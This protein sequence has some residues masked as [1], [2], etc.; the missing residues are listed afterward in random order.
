MKKIISVLTLM[1]ICASLATP[2]VSAEEKEIIANGFW[3]IGENGQGTGVETEI[4]R[5]KF[6][7][8]ID[9]DGL[10]TFNA[11]DSNDNDEIGNQQN[12]ARN[13]WANWKG[14]IKKVVIP[15]G[16]KIVGGRLFE[17]YDSVE[18]AV[19]PDSCET[20]MG[21][22]VGCRNMT[23]INIPKRI[24]DIKLTYSGVNGEIVLPDT[25][26]TIKSE[27]FQGTGIS[28]ITIN[29]SDV[30][31]DAFL[32]AQGLNE[33]YVYGDS[34]ISAY[35]F[36]NTVALNK[37]VL[38]PDVKI[39][40]NAVSSYKEKTD[41]KYPDTAT[42]PDNMKNGTVFGVTGTE[43][44]RYAKNNNIKFS[45]FD[46]IGNAGDVAWNVVD[47]KLTISGSGA[48]P[49]YTIEDAPW[50]GLAD[51]IRTIAISDGVTAIGNN[52]FDGLNNVK[53]AII[54]NGVTRIGTK[55]FAGCTRLAAVVI[56]DSVNEIADDAFEPETAACVGTASVYANKNGFKTYT[57]GK[58]SDSDISDNGQSNINWAVYGNDTLVISGTGRM[59]NTWK[60]AVPWSGYITKLKT[61]VVDYGITWQTQRLFKGDGEKYSSLETVIMADGI[62]RIRKDEI[63]GCTVLKRYDPSNKLVYLEDYVFNGNN[64]IKELVLPGTLKERQKAL[65][66]NSVGFENLIMEE[67]FN[68]LTEDVDN[69][70][71]G[72][73]VRDAGNLKTLKFPKSVTRI[74]TYSF[75]L[76]SNLERIEFLNPDTV[77]ADGAFNECN[78]AK[79]VV[80]CAKDSAVEAWAKRQGMKTETYVGRGDINNNLSWIIT[81][82]GMLKI[83][84]KGA[85]P[86]YSAEKPAPWSGFSGSIAKLYVGNGINAIGS[87]A[88]AGLSSMIEGTIGKD[89]TV[90]GEN[91]FENHNTDLKLVCESD[92][93][94]AYA[95]ANGISVII[96]GTISTGVSW[97][98]EGDT[99]TL[100]GDG[101]VPGALNMSNDVEAPWK[102][103]NGYANSIKN[104]VVEDGIT[105]LPFGAFEGCNNLRVVSLPSTLETVGNLLFHRSYGLEFLEIPQNVGN[106][107]GNGY[108]LAFPGNLKRAVVLSKEFGR[109]NAELSGGDYSK[110]EYKVF[111]YADSAAYSSAIAAGVAV[112]TI[113]AAGSTGEIKWVV[114]N[115]GTLDVYGIGD[116]SEI[117]TAPWAEYN[118]EIKNIYIENGIIGVGTGLFAD[119]QNAYIELPETVTALGE[120]AL[121]AKNTIV[122]VPVYVKTIADNAFDSTVTIYSYKN[123]IALKYAADKGLKCDERKSLR[124]LALGNSYTQDSTKYLYNIAKSC[125]A[126]DIVVGRM[127]HAGSRLFEHL[128]AARNADGYEGWYLY[129]EQ[130]CPDGERINID[131]TS[132]KYGVQAQDWDVIVLQAWYPEACYGL[133]G[134][135]GNGD[136]K[137]E[138]WLNELTKILKSEATNPNVE[139]GFNMIWSQN[140]QLSEAKINDRDNNYNNRFNDGDTTA[141]WQ[142]IVDQTNE[143]IKDNANYKYLIPVGTAVENARTSY[144]GGIRGNLDN[145]SSMVGGLQRDSVH[146]NDIG[147]YIAAMTWAKVLKPEWNVLDTAFVPI[148]KYSG[149]NNI[150]CDE[151]VQKVAKEAVENA[152]NIWNEV[153]PSAY[154]FRIMNYTDGKI[155][156]AASNVVRN[157]LGEDNSKPANI[158]IAEYD[159]GN[160]RL[161]KCKTIHVNLTYDENI[162]GESTEMTPEYLKTVFADG[163]FGISDGNT[164]KVMLINNFNNLMPL[165]NYFEK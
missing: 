125:G 163:G 113:K 18:E 88:F 152:V 19:L 98:I 32:N 95:D 90:I 14:Q 63:G 67:G 124:I 1:C 106:C 24:K 122:R 111:C 127:F 11:V 83:L 142:G 156:I 44:E 147:K 17:W 116:L 75:R 139:L 135:V 155:T 40:D 61:A 35:A 65:N 117:S 64:T 151:D 13:P 39:S 82:D 157:V 72:S 52:A 140:R 150:V 22:F 31:E 144:L 37:I 103:I 62:E 129:S 38:G 159:S 4:V 149:T 146:M 145:G 59:R 154:P 108:S 84:G 99:F 101:E 23:K 58:I 100:Y 160:H 7:W 80:C 34:T 161:V 69:E 42:L 120:N 107:D 51:K 66:F 68:A 29:G 133:N 134:G 43:A 137:D 109:I 153:T 8:K 50:K 114:T 25:V 78:N 143:W 158:V 53:N 60:T 74:G 9:N 87:Y 36:H 21:A 105:R 73:F 27:D 123:A 28:K 132:F 54:P 85:I 3:G 47:T 79:V 12:P 96:G 70:W 57:D 141:D 71:A 126:E 94:K 26:N 138:E 77:I 16:V 41:G 89:V 115:N 119:I 5:D 86:D 48:I 164:V 128:N 33:V 2:F 56:P 92:E 97:K 148:V 46:G 162:N 81:N 136:I 49:D 131:N 112:E 121:N 76:L 55:A 10:F 165:C 91:V 20:L 6:T 110:N 102:N 104:I 15:D 130:T 93:F 45:A 30:S 118:A